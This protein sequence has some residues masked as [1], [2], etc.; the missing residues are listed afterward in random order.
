MSVNEREK[1]KTAVSIVDDAFY[2]NGEIT[3]PGRSYQ[4]NK[5]EGLLLNTRMV[6]GIF[7]DR[8]PETIHL[9]EYPD[10]GAWDPE[11]NTREFPIRD[12]DMARARCIG[13]HY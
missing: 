11:R 3:Y 7:D 4:G 9:W 2:I 8:N 1:M 13:V 12:A 5:I 6:Q 10:T